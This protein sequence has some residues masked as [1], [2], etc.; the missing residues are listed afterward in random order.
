MKLKLFR[1]IKYRLYKYIPGTSQ[2]AALEA[3]RLGKY[4]SENYTEGQQL[5]ILDELHN[6]ICEH[7]RKQIEEKEQLI[8]DES[9]HLKSLQNN[10]EKLINR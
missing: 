6:N 10:L 2:L 8:I 9:N 4:L 5:I 7:R 1:Y 3:Q